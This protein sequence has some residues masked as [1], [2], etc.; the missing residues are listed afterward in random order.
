MADERPQYYENTLSP[1]PV[2]S[3]SLSNT[4]HELRLAVRN[5]AEQIHAND[6]IPERWGLYGMFKHFPGVALAFLRIDYQ[7]PV[8]IGKSG[9]SLDYRRYAL[10]RIPSGFP[11]APLRASRLSAAASLS[12]LPGVILRILA[13]VAQ[14]NWDQDARPC[15][16][17]EDIT[18]LLDATNLALRN[19]CVFTHDD[20]VM[21]ADDMLYGR[22][23]L[24]WALLNVRAHRYDK[25]TERALSPVMET[26]PDLIRVIIDAGRQGSND[27]I[28]KH[29]AQDAHPLMYTWL[30]GHYFFGAVHGIT[31]I[32]TILLACRPEEI[33]NYLPEI[34]DTITTL[35]KLCVA[36]NGHLPMAL[37]PFSYGQRSEFVQLC[38]GSP[39][40]L[41]LLATALKN[42]PLCQAYW[43]PEW[44][45][46][47]YQATW[48]IWEEGLLSKGGSLCHGIAGNAW[49]LL[50]LH[51]SFE[52][53][54]KNI[55][56]ARRGYEQRSQ[57]SLTT[58]LDLSEQLTSDF[59]LSRALA[60]LLHARE[61]RPYNSAPI[62]CN[63]D[64]RMPDDPYSMFEGLAGN[65]CAW[66]DSCAVIQG[67][68][69]K[70][71]LSAQADSASLGEDRVF[72]GA[73]R[74]TLGFPLI[75]G[76][77]AIGLL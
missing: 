57:T 38:H 69:R 18:C 75:G 51:D 37:P 19:G 76:N 34:G 25:E 8:L 66:A 54:S 45:R 4:L 63:K 77:G 6:P 58:D 40:I 36:N 65:V 23:G 42:V 27:Y 7:S 56:E 61:T 30:P 68:L 28:D 53:H 10:Q 60:F 14:T 50:M 74:S 22:A 39:G 21:G 11:D 2:D 64:Y 15:L 3:N 44:D 70:M 48:R 26:I 73:R 1:L 17:L 32:L 49:P 31:G 62:S 16:S 12:P 5:G 24:L 13:T 67:R 33:S 55:D 59:F 29:G 46:T 47:I 52:Y 71:E 72:Q 43:S 20:Q 35:C 9:P 41:I